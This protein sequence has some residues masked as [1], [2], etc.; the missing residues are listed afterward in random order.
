MA[1]RLIQG[2]ASEPVSVAEAKT[3]LRVSHSSEDSYI[4]V[5]I[6]AAREAAEHQLR[7]ALLTQTWRRTLDYF[8]DAIEL[9]YPPLQ[10]VSHV[11]YVDLAGQLQTL[12]SAGYTV[13]DEREPG[14]VVPA[15]GYSWPS[16]LDDINAVEVQFICGWQSAA[17]VPAV[18]RQWILLMTAHHY[19]NREASVP[20]VTMVPLPYLDGLL[21]AYRIY[22]VC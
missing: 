4:G 15:Y 2:P 14:Y 12:A 8:P 5:L 20:G 1:L 9:A 10:S 16:T 19:E 6:T 18:V 17:D 22:A 13:D 7:R 11:K 3:H 21:D